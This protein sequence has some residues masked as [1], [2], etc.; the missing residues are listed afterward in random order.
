MEGAIFF[1]RNIQGSGGCIVGTHLE[2]G[3]VGMWASLYVMAVIISLCSMMLLLQ[4]IFCCMLIH[5]QSQ[6]AYHGD[7]TH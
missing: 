6:Q 1:P 3:V 2:I 4:F 7:T 5:W